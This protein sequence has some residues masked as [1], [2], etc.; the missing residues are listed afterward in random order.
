MAKKLIA[1][2]IVVALFSLC[3]TAAFAHHSF[4]AEFDRAQ[5]VKVTGVV[6][7]VEWT[8][9]HIWYYVEGTDEVSGREAVWGF[10]GASPNSLRRQGISR[11]SLKIGD[12]VIVEGFLARDGS[13]NASGGRV[14]FADGRRVFTASAEDARPD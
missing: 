2:A 8:N 13:A 11:E 1:A 6:R 12:T 7:K 10:S 4:S 9:P 14:T 5:P 3:E